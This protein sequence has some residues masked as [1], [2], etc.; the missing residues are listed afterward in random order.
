MKCFFILVTLFSLT[1]CGKS[2]EQ[3]AK[4]DYEARID[5]AHK[6]FEHSSTSE[7][8]EEFKKYSKGKF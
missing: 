3:Q 1:A 8:V 4:D 6:E 7:G 5:T 2:P